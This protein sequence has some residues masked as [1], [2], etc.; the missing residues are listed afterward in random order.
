MAGWLI[1]VEREWDD[2]EGGYGEVGGDREKEETLVSYA[3]NEF[4]LCSPEWRL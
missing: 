3:Y 1:E 4:V 2:V